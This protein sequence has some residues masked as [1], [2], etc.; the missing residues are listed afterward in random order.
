MWLHSLLL[1]CADTEKP[2]RKTFLV[3][4]IQLSIMPIDLTLISIFNSRHFISVGL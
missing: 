4:W 2:L 3:E 1:A